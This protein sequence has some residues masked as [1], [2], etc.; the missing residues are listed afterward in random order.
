MAPYDG[1]MWEPQRD[2]W[3][4]EAGIVILGED[5]P[6]ELETPVIEFMPPETAKDL[7]LAL[8]L[9]GGPRVE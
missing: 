6:S 9:S 7:A 1:F 8:R 2:A 3:W 5:M 4:N